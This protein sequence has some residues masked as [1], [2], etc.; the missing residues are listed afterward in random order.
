MLSQYIKL[1]DRVRNLTYLANDLDHFFLSGIDTY[2]SYVK[3]HEVLD[4]ISDL[5]LQ[6]EVLEQ[7]YQSKSEPKLAYALTIGSAEKTDI[8]PCMEILE[9]F[10]NSADYKGTTLCIAYFEKG[11]NEYIHIHAYLE[12]DVKWKRS[13]N[14]LQKRHGKYRQKQHNFDIKRLSGLEMTKWKN[15]IKKDSRNSWNIK[16]NNNLKELL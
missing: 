13:Y 8:K 5:Q 4:V 9:K 12:R 7:Q 14:E 1:S 3:C 16:V 11:E 10:K 2:N 6:M 15:Y